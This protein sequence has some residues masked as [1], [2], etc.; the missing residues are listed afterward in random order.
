LFEQKIKLA[1]LNDQYAGTFDLLYN[2]NLDLVFRQLKVS[3]FLVPLKKTLNSVP[4]LPRCWRILG[5]DYSQEYALGA[6]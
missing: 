4:N 3:L 6:I 2:Y 1:S 5:W